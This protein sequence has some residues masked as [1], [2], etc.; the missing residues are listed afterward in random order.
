MISLTSIAIEKIKSAIDSQGENRGL[1]IAVTGTG[2]SGLQYKMT[3]DKEHGETDEVLD[4]EG[5]R[6]IIDQ[7]SLIYLNG[8]RIDYIDNE[9][10]AGFQFDN[11]NT[12]PPCGC[13]DTFEV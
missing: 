13:G 9:T 2:C 8:T 4:I 5:I 3:L 1:R 10:G 11:P 12:R 7:Q 6:L